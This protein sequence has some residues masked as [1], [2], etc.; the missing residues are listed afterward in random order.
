[1]NEAR[2]RELIKTLFPKKPKPHND[3]C[4]CP[5]CTYDRLEHYLDG[6]RS[7]Y[8]SDGSST[9]YGD[10]G[11][12]KCKKCGRAAIWVY[13]TYTYYRECSRQ[14]DGEVVRESY[15]IYCPTCDSLTEQKKEPK[16]K[17]QLKEK[18]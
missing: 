13:H 2:R 8:Y 12:C 11:V 16:N 9:S 17:L 14:F 18:K 3:N 10:S 5:T 15:Q 6:L 7:D 1:M 4:I